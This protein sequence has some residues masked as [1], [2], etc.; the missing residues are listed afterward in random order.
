MKH[1]LATMPLMFGQL[2]LVWRALVAAE[3]VNIGSTKSCD[4]LP[5]AEN[6]SLQLETMPV[7]GRLMHSS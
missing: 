3:A 7:L 6:D 5:A 1:E 4:F 2:F